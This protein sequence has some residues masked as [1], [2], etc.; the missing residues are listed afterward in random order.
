MVMVATRVEEG[1]AVEGVDE[2]AEGEVTHTL[3]IYRERVNLIHNH[4]LIEGKEVY[5]PQVEQ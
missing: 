1:E 2:V 5:R 4:L 3:P